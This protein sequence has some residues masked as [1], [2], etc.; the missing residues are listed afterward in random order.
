M[1]K[2][3]HL[4]P[5]GAFVVLGNQATMAFYIC[6]CISLESVTVFVHI[7]CVAVQR[8]TFNLVLYIM[9]PL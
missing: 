9:S 8:L 1:A 7:V 4:V 3:P 5:V 2:L 6:Y